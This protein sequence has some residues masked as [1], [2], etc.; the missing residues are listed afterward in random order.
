MTE[1]K[2]LFKNR[3]DVFQA[4]TSQIMG[5]LT[6]VIE[7]ANNFVHHREESTGDI[8]WEDVSFF[9][10]EKLVL[11]VGV[12]E[13]KP[14]DI[15]YVSEGSQIEVTENTASYFK[16]LLRLGI[17]YGL[18]I[19]GTPQ[20]VFEFLKHSAERVETEELEEQE[21]FIDMSELPTPPV[22]V[23]EF[24]L[25][26]LTEEQREQLRLFALSYGGKNE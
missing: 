17:P 19:N 22:D 16:R 14:G 8:T 3:D 7:G 13:Y 24:D 20:E 21:M 9:E 4:L 6:N 12:L 10:D 1:L 15:V 23:P 5:L 26:D 25:D 18:A 11:L 2:E